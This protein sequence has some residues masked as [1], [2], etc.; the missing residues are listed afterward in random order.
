MKALLYIGLL[1]ALLMTGCRK[2]TYNT[3][4]K[5]AYFRFFNSLNYALTANNKDEPEPYITMVVDPTYDANGV[6]TGGAVVGD[7][8]DRRLAY[9]PPYPANAGNTSLDNYEYPGSEK[10]LAGPILNGFDLSSWAQ[11]TSGSHRFVFFSRPVS[12]TPFFQLAAAER[13]FTFADTTVNLAD[14]Q[15]YTMELLT[16]DVSS[17]PLKI[18]FY[19]RKESFI[20]QSFDS[21]RC[22]VN[23]YNLGAEGF[24]QQVINAYVPGQGGG[25]TAIWDTMN[26]YL[27]LHYPD[28]VSG[29]GNTVVPGF[30]YVPFGS[31]IRSHAAGVAPYMSFPVFPAYG[32][33]DTTNI[34][35]RI[36]EEITFLSPDYV[37]Q[38]G[39]FPSYNSS[40]G[41]Y[42]QMACT[43]AY[44]AKGPFGIPNTDTY[45]SPN[46]VITI[47]SGTYGNRSFPT[48]SS[49]EIINGHSYVMSVQRQYAPPVES[50]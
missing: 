18:E 27:T 43:A 8:L 4:S 20:T 26:V 47:P 33:S 46:L 28:S 34:H 24:T 22:Y 12:L 41:D 1:G 11:I 48:I 44:Y 13:K 40:L 35:S 25:G 32:G 50:F 2:F 3:I 15:V 14:G 29:A 6:V 38:L 30:Q 17:N 39:E 36:W 23:F 7:F 16:H 31:I 45:A 5:P 9:A 10:V 37:P 21:S 49:V 42:A 19:M